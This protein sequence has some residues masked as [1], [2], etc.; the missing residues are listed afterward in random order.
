MLGPDLKGTKQFFR[1]VFNASVHVRGPYRSSMERTE[2]LMKAYHNTTALLKTPSHTPPV[3]DRFAF[4]EM[5]LEF[6]GEFTSLPAAR[7]REHTDLEPNFG[8]VWFLTGRSRGRP[9]NAV[10]E[11]VRAK[12]DASIDSFRQSWNQRGV[13]KADLLCR[14]ASSH[15][16]KWS[17]DKSKAMRE[18]LGE[19]CVDAILAGSALLSAQCS[20]KL[21]SE[22]SAA[23]LAWEENIKGESAFVM[24]RTSTSIQR[25]KATLYDGITRTA[26]LNDDYEDH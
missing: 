2:K 7:F 14:V 22:L 9:L 17:D 12:P 25:L 8:F 19:E 23:S 18:L 4:E 24:L 15:P 1:G 10:T 16:T 5:M 3:F 21:A 6:P 26:C 13:P 20:A 11:T